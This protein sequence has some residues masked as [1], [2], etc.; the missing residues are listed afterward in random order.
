MTFF[1]LLLGKGEYSVF[2]KLPDHKKYSWYG[3]SGETY[4]ISHLVDKTNRGLIMASLYTYIH[5]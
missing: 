3:K 5:S 2:T 4:S 1:F